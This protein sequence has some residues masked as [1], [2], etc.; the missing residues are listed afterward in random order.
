MASSATAAPD[1]SV[2]ASVDDPVNLAMSCFVGIL[3]LYLV[4][5]FSLEERKR[6]GKTLWL[7]ESGPAILLGSILG[8]LSTPSSSSNPSTSR[9]LEISDTTFFYFVLPPIIFAQ[10]YGLKK[11]NFF[12]YIHYITV[13]GVLGTFLQFAFMTGSLYM[14]GQVFDITIEKEDGTGSRLSLH[15]AMIISACLAAADEVAALSLIKSSSH[16]K[17]SAILFGEGVVNDAISILLFHSVVTTKRM[18]PDDLT[19]ESRLLGASNDDDDDAAPKN[20]YDDDALISPSPT[21]LPTTLSPSSPSSHHHAKDIAQTVLSWDIQFNKILTNTCKTL[22]MAVIIGVTSGLIVSRFLKLYPQMKRSPVHQTAI[23]LLGAYLSFCISDA[24][25]YSGVLTVFFSGLTLSHYAWHSLSKKAQESTKTT[26]AT[27]SQVAEGYCFAAVGVSLRRFERLEQVSFQLVFLSIVVLLA[28]RAITIFGCSY[29]GSIVNKRK[30]DMPLKEQSVL[31]AG[32]LIR[33][34]ICWAQ[35]IQVRD[36]HRHVMLSTTLGVILF[37]TLIIGSLLPWWVKRME[38]NDDEG[39][40]TLSWHAES[41][42][43]IPNTPKTNNISR[44]EEESES[45]I[46]GGAREDADN[47]ANNSIIKNFDSYVMKPVFGGSKKLLPL[48]ADGGQTGKNYGSV[49]E[50]P[51]SPISFQKSS[52]DD[53]DL[54]FLK[55]EKVE[56]GGLWS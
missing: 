42:L 50:A 28:G 11:R 30:F 26:F 43:R 37:T 25:H 32:G 15:E 55:T 48:K 39:D 31:Y 10:G 9:T 36:P 27:I 51:L 56:T 13:F 33:G 21:P 52:D 19:N 5:G 45:L 47:P 8:L 29:L 34:A 24:F 20:S 53:E 35:A 2:D 6:S 23:I 49:G 17:L 38:V 14:G 41:P 12:K 7:H 46:L 3:L 22:I 4:L 54:S 18:T 1:A 16:P 44:D 40:G